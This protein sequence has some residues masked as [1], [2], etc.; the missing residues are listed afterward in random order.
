MFEAKS[1]T[2]LKSLLVSPNLSG[3]KPSD[4]V[5]IFGDKIVEDDPQLPLIEFLRKL[6]QAG[7]QVVVI[8][9][10]PK[11][12]EL[13][14]Q[15]PRSVLLS[16]P[17]RLNSILYSF[18][19]F[20]INLEPLP[21]G[22]EDINISQGITPQWSSLPVT[23][24]PVNAN[25]FSSPNLP[26]N[27]G[28]PPVASFQPINPVEQN[29]LPNTPPIANPYIEPAQNAFQNNQSYNPQNEQ[30]YPPQNNTPG[31]PGSNWEPPQKRTLADY[32]QQPNQQVQGQ[33]PMQGGSSAGS[34]TGSS[35][36]SQSDD[37]AT[38][39]PDQKEKD[40]AEIEKILTMEFTL[41]EA[42]SNNWIR[43]KNRW[44]N[45]DGQLV[46]CEWY[47]VNSHKTTIL[48]VR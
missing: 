26:V 35:V 46:G 13:Q 47:N 30:N 9:V 15:A 14:R 41:E 18:T 40:A 29:T 4:I 31:M 8:S 25:A 6:T 19:N 7:Y 3:V 2:E 42:T 16:L 23:D 37:L 36:G 27:Q 17:I 48:S 39:S 1:S 20:G 11:G 38:R 21:Y 44:Y 22:N 10:T 33:D 28:V 43:N 32:A 12:A 45:V 5:F 34:Q 24:A